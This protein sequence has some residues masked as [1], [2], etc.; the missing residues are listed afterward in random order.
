MA[1]KIYLDVVAVTGTV[2]K[3]VIRSISNNNVQESA[4]EYAVKMAQFPQFSQLDNMLMAGNLGVEHM[5]TIAH[6]VAH[7][8]NSIPRVSILENSKNYG[9]RETIS[10]PILDNFKHIREH[11]NDKRYDS[12]LELLKQ[13][14]SAELSRLTSLFEQRI[15][16]GLSLI[17]I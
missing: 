4:F 7:F 3:P 2:E 16:E 17:H 8:H 12:D 6:M 15:T 14:F 1:D 11:L 5:D 13:W 9:S 10:K